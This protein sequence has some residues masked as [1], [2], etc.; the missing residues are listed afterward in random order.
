MKSWGPGSADKD[1]AIQR[2]KIGFFLQLPT[3]N[4]SV[5]WA[6]I[7][8]AA[9]SIENNFDASWPIKGQIAPLSMEEFCACSLEK[10]EE[11]NG[12]F[13]VVAHS[14][15]ADGLRAGVSDLFLQFACK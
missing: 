13:S 6:F 15:Q 1:I 14:Q 12:P 9:S 11:E 4:S 5:L 10:S 3:S 8:W 2:H 7:R